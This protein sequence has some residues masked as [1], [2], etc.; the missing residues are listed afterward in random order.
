LEQEI[1]MRER[2]LKHQIELLKQEREARQEEF[3]RRFEQSRK[4]E[5]DYTSQIKQEMD[6]KAQLQSQL[7]S[8]PSQRPPP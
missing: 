5:M 6:K 7:N 1:Q 2:E 3:N 8:L 4:Q